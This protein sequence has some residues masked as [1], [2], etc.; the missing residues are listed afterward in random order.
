MPH[1][2]DYGYGV[3]NY[4]VKSG[5]RCPACGKTKCKHGR[6]ARVF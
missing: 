3:T 4:T 1:G 6:K 2:S 5:K